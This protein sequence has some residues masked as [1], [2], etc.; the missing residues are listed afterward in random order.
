[1]DTSGRVSVHALRIL[2]YTILTKALI[3]AVMFLCALAAWISL[4]VASPAIQIIEILFITSVAAG[5]LNCVAV[6]MC[7][8]GVSLLSKRFVSTRR[9]MVAVLLLWCSAILMAIVQIGLDGAGCSSAAAAAGD[10][11]LT[12]VGAEKLLTGA[13]FLFITKGFGEALR[14]E[15]DDVRPAAM[16]R[17]GR[18]YYCFTIFSILLMAVGLLKFVPAFLPVQASL[19]LAGAVLEFMIYRRVSDAAFRIWRK[20]AFDVSMQR[21]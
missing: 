21:G 20:R 2:T 14:E 3:S 5:F 16:E 10:L 17:L 15:G 19:Y 6:M 7:L 1:M 9:I 11:M 8:G 12:S 4:N 13:A 18:V